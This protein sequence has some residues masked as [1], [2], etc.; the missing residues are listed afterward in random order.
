MKIRYAVAVGSR[1]PE[2]TKEA[3]LLEGKGGA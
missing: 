2:A 3:S 1:N